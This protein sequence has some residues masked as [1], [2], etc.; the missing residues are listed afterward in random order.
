MKKKLLAFALIAGMWFTTTATAGLVVL[1][2]GTWRDFNYTETGGVDT[3]TI[4]GPFDEFVINHNHTAAD[5]LQV[6]FYQTNGSYELVTF[7]MPI[8][9]GSMTFK[10]QCDSIKIRSTAGQTNV[11]TKG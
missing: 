10:I 4:N 6:S 8:G 2:V 3:T 9:G 11:F 5:T 1:Q 7:A